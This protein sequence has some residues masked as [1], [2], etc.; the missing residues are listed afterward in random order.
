MWCPQI[1]ETNQNHHCCFMFCCSSEGPHFHSFN[2]QPQGTSLRWINFWTLNKNEIQLTIQILVRRTIIYAYMHECTTRNAIPTETCS[3]YH[4]TEYFRCFRGIR[5]H[6]SSFLW[7]YGTLFRT[8]SKVLLHC[9]IYLFI[10]LCAFTPH[11]THTQTSRNKGWISKCREGDKEE[12]N[13]AD[14]E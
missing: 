3:G 5:T 12:D 11:P 7:Y 8:L 4:K 2:I 6:L 14:S 1:M 9:S 13:E 10:Y